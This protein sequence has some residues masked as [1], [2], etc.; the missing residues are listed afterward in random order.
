MVS[1]EIRNTLKE[2][3][4][5]QYYEV[6][7]T[8]TFSSSGYS[9]Y[10]AEQKKKKIEQKMRNAP[11]TVDID[12]SIEALDESDRKWCVCNRSTYVDLS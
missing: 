7:P 11:N 12:V 1:I 10:Q 6:Y 2:E 9:I 3:D 8:G 4:I 5:K